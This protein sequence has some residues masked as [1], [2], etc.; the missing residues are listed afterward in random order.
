MSSLGAQLAQTH[1]GTQEL[2]PSQLRFEAAL[3]DESTVWWGRRSSGLQL[4]FPPGAEDRAHPGF[5][6]TASEN[7][8]SSYVWN[9]EMLGC[10]ERDR[11]GDEVN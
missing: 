10:N 6:L 2:G 1:L 11:D 4:D 3:R 7:S 5:P 9:S 8:E